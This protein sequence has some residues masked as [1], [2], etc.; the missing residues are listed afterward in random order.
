LSSITHSEILEFWFD[1]SSSKRWFNSTPEFDKYIL[2]NYQGIWEQA[3]NGELDDW[4]TTPLG[5]LSLT[6]ILDQFPLNM[7]RGTA[8]SYS[9]ESK[10]ITVTHKAIYNKFD[11]KLNITQLPFLYMP[12]MHSEKIEDQNEAVRL[13]EKPGLENNLKFS[14]H[15]QSIIKRFGR[16]PH[17]NEALNRASTTAELN[18][19]SSPEA[20]KG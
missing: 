7:F 4:Q 19:L 6:I 13:F 11:L 20:F 14:K 8:K 15:H 10:A 1:E 5:S 16:F 18:Y 2:T 12:L 3:Y 17:R 9:T